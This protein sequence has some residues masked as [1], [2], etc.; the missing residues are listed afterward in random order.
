[1]TQTETVWKVKRFPT[2]FQISCSSV[3]GSFISLMFTLWIRLSRTNIR[4]HC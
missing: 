1:M 2:L 3:V 4:M